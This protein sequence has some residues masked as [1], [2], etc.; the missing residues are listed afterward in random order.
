MMQTVFS[1]LLN[2]LWH[3][4]EFLMILAPL[5]LLAGV[6]QAMSVVLRFL[7]LKLAG[8]KLWLILAAPGTIVH[9]SAHALF[10][11]I[12]RHEIIEMKL[13]S[14]EGDT[15]GYVNHAWDRRSFY[16]NAGNLFIGVAPIIV[17]TAVICIFTFI[18]L[19]AVPGSVEMREFS[20][21]TGVLKAAWMLCWRMLCGLADPALLCRWQSWVHLLLLLLIGSH[22]TLSPADFK[23]MKTGAVT[24]A[25]GILLVNLIFSAW[26]NPA[27]FLLRGIGGFLVLACGLMLFTAVL[28]G[29]AALFLGVILKAVKKSSPSA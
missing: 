24:L 26:G 1:Y 4:F 20:S 16:Q 22:I 21:L 14:P 10:C 29:I 6:L 17:G 23:G 13:F 7:T 18:L 19:P 27:D 11:L 25:G 3:S 5:G 8:E 2:V 9:E 12:F 15:L 28:L